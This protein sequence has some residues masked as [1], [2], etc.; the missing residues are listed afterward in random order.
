MRLHRIFLAGFAMALALTGCASNETDAPTE[1]TVGRV[2]S[3]TLPP[4]TRPPVQCENQNLDL[5]ETAFGAWLGSQI[6]P[7]DQPGTSYYFTVADNQFNPCSDL[8]WVMLSGTN[9]N[10]GQDDG[11]GNGLVH[12]LVFFT[13]E[14]L[15]TDPAPRQFKEAASVERID[16]RS[17]TVTYRRTAESVTEEHPVD[18]R[19]DD[20]RLLGEERLPAEQRDNVRLD[21]TRV[22]PPT[23]DPP[24]LFGNANYRPWDQEFPMGRQYSLMMGE[25]KIACDF[26]TFNGMQLVCYSET[27][28]PW[29]LKTGDRE[30]DAG[31]M[32]NIALLNFQDPGEVRTDVGT[33]P[34]QESTFEMLPDASVTRIG[35]IIIDTRSDV[36]KIHD[37]NRAY[38]LG[39]GIAETLGV[40]T[41]QLDTSRYPQDL[42]PWEG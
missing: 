38:L 19:L 34:S 23:E 16:D 4:T 31:S 11:N 20:G 37:A 42:I 6:I 29:P 35:D 33:F 15:F 41:L 26:A 5:M 27:A 28:L 40:P 22:G 3:A 24:R 32:A 9:G 1:V 10:A 39:E 14:D 30:A 13:G 12:A 7:T 36:V 2:P 21:L 17:I 8:S 25:K 18:Y